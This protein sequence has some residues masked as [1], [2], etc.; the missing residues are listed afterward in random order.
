MEAVSLDVS[1]FVEKLHLSQAVSLE[2][3]TLIMCLYPAKIIM[4]GKVKPK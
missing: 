4:D 3:H 2:P 1:P